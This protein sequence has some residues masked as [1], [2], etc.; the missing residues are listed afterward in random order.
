[1]VENSRKCIATQLIVSLSSISS[2]V[3][4]AFKT[5]SEFLAALAGHLGFQSLSPRLRTSLYA[6]YYV[7]DQG[8][9]K[10]RGWMGRV[11]LEHFLVTGLRN[12]SPVESSAPNGQ[13]KYPDLDREDLP[14]IEDLLANSY[15]IDF[16]A[17]LND[18]SESWPC[19]L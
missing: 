5:A 19:A 18:L 7:K 15:G 4:G 11:W 16:S 2:C 3:L 17:I 10:L 9:C 1:M 14:N 8:A 12:H 13:Y 6:R